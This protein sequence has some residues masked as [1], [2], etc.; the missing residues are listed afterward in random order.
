M[1]TDDLARGTQT[2]LPIS[3]IV[4]VAGRPELLSQALASILRGSALP[5]ELLVIVDSTGPDRV[6]DCAAARTVLAQSPVPS[7]ILFTDGMG[8]AGARNQGARESSRPWL[9]FLDSDDLWE[10]EKLR[11]QWDYMRRRPHL[12]ASQTGE[13]WWKNGRILTQPARLRP[14]P[15]RF[16]NDAWAHCLVSLSSTLIRRAVFFETGA[17]D[18][19]F[20][21]CEDFEFWLRF[22]SRAPLGLVP[23]ALVVK[24]SG[25][26]PQLSAQPALDALRIRAILKTVRTGSLALVQVRQ[27]E[28]SCREKLAILEQGAENRGL[29]DKFADLRQSIEAVFQSNLS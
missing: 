23:D 17:F 22:L 5:T 25:G 24:R 15:G 11:V 14:R 10:I 2:V 21:A 29:P 18:E 9:A 19:S 13:T 16:L 4:P 6:A 28:K 12:D 7:R 26:W 20:P 1:M 8:P 3:A 27:A